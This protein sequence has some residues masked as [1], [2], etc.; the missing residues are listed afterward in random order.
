M[1]VNCIYDELLAV[2]YALSNC[3]SVMMWDDDAADIMM[4][5]VVR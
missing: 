5:M 3:S 1:M 4:M 2:Y